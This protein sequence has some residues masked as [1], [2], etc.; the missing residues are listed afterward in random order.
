[1]TSELPELQNLRSV[2]DREIYNKTFPAKIII[3]EQIQILA[4]IKE[5]LEESEL[6]M[7]TRSCFRNFLDLDAS[8][9]EGGKSAKRNTF[10]KKLVHF[11]ML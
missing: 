1:M 6:E 5:K 10:A 9:I 4:E 8:W 11:F 3:K 7:F 2:L